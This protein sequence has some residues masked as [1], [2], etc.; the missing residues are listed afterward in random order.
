[1]FVGWSRSDTSV[2]CRSAVAVLCMER[3]GLVKGKKCALS[4]VSSY[5]SHPASSQEIGFLSLGSQSSPSCVWGRNA[6]CSHSQELGLPQLGFLLASCSSTLSS[7]RSYLAGTMSIFITSSSSLCAQA[8]EHRGRE[9]P[10]LVWSQC[11]T[12]GK[13]VL[14]DLPEVFP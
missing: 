3:I 7:P 1:M 2:F 14:S 5:H 10:T 12:C 8:G 13:V 9:F 4:V 6:V 11:S